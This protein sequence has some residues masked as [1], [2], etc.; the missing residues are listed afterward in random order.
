MNAANDWNIKARGNKCAKCS[1]PFLDAQPCV[2]RLHFTSEGY[3]RADFCRDCWAV[4][5]NSGSGV[6]VWQGVY[7]PPPPPPPEPIKKETAESLLK[8][9][10]A[11][12]DES[13]AR[14]IYI[15][16]VMLERRRIL[17]ER[18]VQTRPD[19][20]KFRI[21]EHKKNG[22]TYVVLDPML[23]PRDIEHVQKEV[24][25]LLSAAIAPKTPEEQGTANDRPCDNGGNSN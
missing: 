12:G 1:T 15:L 14:T 2:S 8:N 18:D 4:E 5:A 11:A 24:S 22:E 21:Y 6:S 7:R 19:G 13:K 10:V 9:L 25:E 20:R 16:A 3:T 23:N 17:V